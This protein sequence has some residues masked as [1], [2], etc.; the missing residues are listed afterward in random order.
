MEEK[1]SFFKQKID[2]E[3]PNRNIVPLTTSIGEDG[4]LSIG[5]CSIEELVSK[6]DSP[7]YIL[8][9]ITL[10]NSCKALHEFLRVISSKMY[11]GESYLLTNSSI[12]HPP[13]DNF[14]SSP[15]DVVRG[16]IFLLGLSRS[17]FCLKKDFFSSMG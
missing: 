17:I 2:L 5:G 4:K 12:E 7:L 15:I 10:R 11:R 3:S 14:P 6:Y 13:I 16:T 8:D 9:E 1:K